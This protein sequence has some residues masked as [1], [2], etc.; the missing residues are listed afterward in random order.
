[1]QVPI[2]T[3]RP[4]AIAGGRD[5]NRP[6]RVVGTLDDDS[7]V[8]L[9]S[10]I[11]SGPIIAVPSQ[12]RAA[13]P[14]PNGIFRQEKSW[15]ISSVVTRKTRPDQK[16]GGSGGGC[17]PSKCRGV[18]GTTAG[19]L[20]ERHRS[21]VLLKRMHTCLPTFQ[22]MTAAGVA[23]PTARRPRPGLQFST[24]CSRLFSRLTGQ[25][26]ANSGRCRARRSAALATVANKLFTTASVLKSAGCNLLI[27]RACRTRTCDHLVRSL[28]KGDNRG[29][30]D[31]AAPMFTGLF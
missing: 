17:P 16:T 8:A 15:P 1:V 25:N 18:R 12:A 7:L 22:S 14:P 13:A 24:R 9:V 28:K 11:R 2:S 5:L 21:A 4:D 6:F 3:A 31:A 29:Q 23:R 30:R 19:A 26:P 20:A 27:W 10:F